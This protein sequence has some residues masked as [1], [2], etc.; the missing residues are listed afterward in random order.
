MET[1]KRRSKELRAVAKGGVIVTL[2][3]LSGKL[4][5]FLLV[6]MIV[7]LISKADFGVISLAYVVLNVAATISI[8]GLG[9]GLARFIARYRAQ[10]GEDDVGR[11]IASGVL[12]V[13]C[14]ATALSVLMYV[15]S[16]TLSSMFNN[17]R[18][19]DV[20]QVFSFLLLPMAGIQIISSIFQGLERSLPRFIFQ[21]VMIYLVRL[22]LV[23]PL[24]LLDERFSWVVWSYVA[25]A[26]VTFLFAAAYTVRALRFYAPFGPS[27]ALFAELL[28][29][30]IPLFGVSLIIKSSAWI[31]VILLGL[32]ATASDV[33]GF[34]VALRLAEV[35][36]IGIMALG[37]IFMPMATRAVASK[38]DAGV[39]HLYA[40][41]TKWASIFSLPLLLFVAL[42]ADYLLQALFSREYADSAAMLQ[43]LSAGYFLHTVLGLNGSTLLAYGESNQVF[44]GSALYGATTAGV[45]LLLTHSLGGLGVAI[46]VTLGLSVYNVYLT[47]VLYRRYGIKPLNR[48]NY[49]PIVLLSVMGAV[50]GYLLLQLVGEIA[51]AHVAVLLALYLTAFLSLWWTRSLDATDIDLLAALERKMTG[52][53]RFAGM[54]ERHVK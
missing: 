43:V 22:G 54:L 32:W 33:A 39:A 10:G 49:K 20:F 13:V 37:F 9:T 4:L 6:V 25:S 52:K 36:S 16:P 8:L 7:R 24:F 28:R 19:Q 38:D 31:G 46:A 23:A 45:A 50:C 41:T 26:W 3:R 53:S 48:G 51:V 40:S 29:F 2:G 47:A 15:F 1:A 34:T 17:D 18:L 44:I 42:D 11:I 30:S 12:F 5:R 21:D 35:L 14:M 27:A